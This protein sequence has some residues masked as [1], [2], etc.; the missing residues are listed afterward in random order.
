MQQSSFR[1]GKIILG[2]ITCLILAGI[3]AAMAA[4]GINA[5]SSDGGTIMIMYFPQG[6]AVYLNG[7]YRGVAPIILQNLTP[8]NYDVAVSMAGYNNDTAPV[9]LYDGST[10]EIGFNLVPIT[11]TT[12]STIGSGSIAVDSSPGGAVILLDGNTVGI[13]RMDGYAFNLDNVQSGN[14]IV[15]MEL[16]G[17][18]AYTSTVTVIRNQVV[19][20]HADFASQTPTVPG[21]SIPTTGRPESVPLT[22]LTAIA[23]AGLACIAVVFRRS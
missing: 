8:G 23:A 1:N 14:H 10:R 18:P 9:T 22:P 2:I 16:D 6:A 15:T 20:V 17:Y 12:V 3:P 13:T 5:T 19:K 21:T 4:D 7:E 11:K